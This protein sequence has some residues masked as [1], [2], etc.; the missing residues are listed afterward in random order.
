MGVLPKSMD[1]NYEISVPDAV[2]EQE[3]FCEYAYDFEKNEL[4]T[5]DGRHYYVYGNKAMEIWIY[6]CML[7]SRFR[8]S[9]YTDRFGTEVYSLVGEV[10]SSKLKQEEI[11][12]YI[13][14][15]VMVHPFMKAI[16]DIILEQ[17]RDGLNVTVDYKTVFN[18]EVVRVD[19]V[20]SIE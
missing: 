17:K 13:V 6:K 16:I 9:A 10:I 11:K 3:G 2:L 19:C 4:K 18:D 14:E 5:K 20:V 15:A 8:Y 7:T 12:R 1:L